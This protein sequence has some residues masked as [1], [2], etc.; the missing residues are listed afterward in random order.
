MSYGVENSLLAKAEKFLGKNPV[1]AKTGILESLKLVDPGEI[2][3]RFIDFDRVLGKLNKIPSAAEPIGDLLH[4]LI[5]PSDY[6][7]ATEFR[8]EISK[9]KL[10]TLSLLA[11][12][13]PVMTDGS[14]PKTFGEVNRLISSGEWRF[15]EA[16]KK[17]P[18]VALTGALIGIKGIY[19]QKT[20]PHIENPDFP[21]NRQFVWAFKE[22]LLSELPYSPLVED[23]AQLTI[24][25]AKYVKGV[26][27]DV[28][29]FSFG[30]KSI[31]SVAQYK[32]K[33]STHLG[34]VDSEV[35]H[36]IHTM[37]GPF[38]EELA[39]NLQERGLNAQV[40]TT[41]FS[42]SSEYSF[43]VVHDGIDQ[44]LVDPTIGKFLANHPQVFVGTYDQLLYL[45][46]NSQNSRFSTINISSN[47]DESVKRI[48][49]PAFSIR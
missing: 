15:L 13:T 12:Q 7:H 5:D 41:A 35:K 49:G 27:E 40:Y 10:D 19:V 32:N 17:D 25:S 46:R 39:G 6:S 3:Q 4:G 34:V 24:E 26:T 28:L 37:S 16:F 29:R 9:G 20:H 45:A 1:V 23:T 2:K 31:G 8:R 36:A 38:S 44:V 14:C 11:M 47:P 18:N 21:L 42:P 30:T 48:W 43:V 33:L 22:V